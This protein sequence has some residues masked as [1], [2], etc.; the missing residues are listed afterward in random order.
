MRFSKCRLR[1]GEA[2]GYCKELITYL[3]TPILEHSAKSK[4]LNSGMLLKCNAEKRATQ[5]FN[6]LLYLE[7]ELDFMVIR[8]KSPA[9]AGPSSS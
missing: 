4:N 3:G 7:N 6:E 8:K 2:I 9:K 1:L 5:L